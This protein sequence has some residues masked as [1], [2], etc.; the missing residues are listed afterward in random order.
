MCRWS[1]IMRCLQMWLCLQDERSI[2][3]RLLSCG[4]QG[5]GRSLM[6][7]LEWDSLRIPLCYIHVF[8]MFMR[9]MTH[10]PPAPFN[11]SLDFPRFQTSPAL[12]SSERTILPAG[13]IQKENRVNIDALALMS[14]ET[15]RCD[16][17]SYLFLLRKGHL[18]FSKT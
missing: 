4:H 11:I 12:R 18:P 1:V 8:R 10:S 9:I 5:S 3:G 2:L 17:V 16:L 15:G 7:G 14:R 6:K 13:Q